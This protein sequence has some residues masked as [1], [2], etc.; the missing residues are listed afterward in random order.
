M[1]VLH[2]SDTHFVEKARASDRKIITAIKNR[3]PSHLLIITGDVADDGY[4]SQYG[5]A[6]GLLVALP[7]NILMCPGNHDYGVAGT[8][9]SKECEQHYQDFTRKLLR[10]AYNVGVFVTDDV[11]FVRVIT[12]FDTNGPF[13]F[14][15]GQVGETQMAWIKEVLEDYKDKKKVVYLHHHPWIHTDPFMRL[16]DADEFLKVCGD[17][18]VDVLLFG[19]KHVV[20]RWHNYKGIGDGLACGRTT[21]DGSAWELQI[22][23]SQVQI[24]QVNLLPRRKS[25]PKGRG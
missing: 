8:I 20:G 4:V 12:P 1:D 3:Y 13:E 23:A 11:V 17:A 5:V 18:K 22:T 19:H 16:I 9:Y 24:T 21:A 2:I 6:Y 25:A 10:D 7:N 14:A 15:C